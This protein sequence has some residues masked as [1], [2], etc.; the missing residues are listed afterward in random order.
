[1]TSTEMLVMADTAGEVRDSGPIENAY[2]GWKHAD[3]AA[4]V[5]EREM[6]ET[7]RRFERGVCAPPSSALLREAAS[8][9]HAAREKLGEVMAL[10]H[11]AGA[12]QGASAARGALSS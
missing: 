5:I 2:D 11:W 3:A 8:L 7:W 9:R 1:M 6:T 12:V 10:L 4:R